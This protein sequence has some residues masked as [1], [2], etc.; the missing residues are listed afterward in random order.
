VELRVF[1]RVRSIRWIFLPLG[2]C[3]LCAV[4]AHAAADVM[5]D[6]IY[7]V[8]D[9]IDAFFDGIFARW[10]VTAPLVDLVGLPQR[11]FFARGIALVWELSADALLALPLLDYRERSATD[12]WTLSVA[13]LRRRPSLKLLPPI[14]M[15]FL[16]FA[17]AE[18]V[19]RMVQ[20]SLL[21]F[22]LVAK[23]LGAATLFLLMV[24]FLPR[25]AFRSLEHEASRKTAVSV[26]ALVVL[27]PLA[28]AA[29]STL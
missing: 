21:H 18:A 27:T 17:G 1:E 3:A 10:S 11:T 2:L 8:V 7:S 12:E 26:I 14:A 29:V 13:M 22:A 6:R 19:A 24:F 15:L 20:G 5:G 4:G 16:G 25:A 28:L 23:L 9:A